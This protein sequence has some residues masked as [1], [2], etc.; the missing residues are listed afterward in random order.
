[1]AQSKPTAVTSLYLQSLNAA[2]D[3]SEENQAALENRI[4]GAIWFALFLIALLACVALGFGLRQRTWFA[5]LIV[6][7]TISIVMAL[8]AD[9]DSPRKGLI[10]VSRQ[11]M[12]RVQSDLKLPY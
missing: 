5:L 9:L 4:P 10:R 2:I 8:I 6:P 1:V 11:S 12:E 3:L 7:M